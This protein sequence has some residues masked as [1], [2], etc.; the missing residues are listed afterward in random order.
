MRGSEFQRLS[1]SLSPPPAGCRTRRG[2]PSPVCAS[3]ATPSGL[4]EPTRR[5]DRSIGSSRRQ[6]AKIGLRRT[7][8]RRRLAKRNQI[9]PSAPRACEPVG[10][11]DGEVP[12][13]ERRRRG[14]NPV[15]AIVV[16]ARNARRFGREPFRPQRGSAPP[17]VAKPSGRDRSRPS[18]GMAAHARARLS[19]PS[20]GIRRSRSGVKY[21][22]K[23]ILAPCALALLLGFPA[24]A[25]NAAQTPPICR[26]K[27]L[28]QLT[29]L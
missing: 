4:I 26:G 28:T 21:D 16:R 15:S 20:H 9:G 10:R 13:S 22:M 1:P 19:D 11:R 7:L 5:E 25:L 2:P 23:A 6:W 14:I 8:R 29:L 24:E 12:K 3:A 18:S 27:D 17:P